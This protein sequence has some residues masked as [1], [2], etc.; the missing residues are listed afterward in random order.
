VAEA[1]PSASAGRTERKIADEGQFEL[2]ALLRSKHKR[3]GQTYEGALRAFADEANPECLVHAAHSMRE[4]FDALPVA[5][6]IERKRTA[7]LTDQVRKISTIWSRAIKTS[8]SLTAEGWKGE[9]D[10][11]LQRLLGEIAG[12][13]KWFDDEHPRH[14]LV[15]DMALDRLDPGRGQLPEQLR[16]ERARTLD[17]LTRY[18]NAVAHHEIDSSRAEFAERLAQSESFLRTFFKP[19]PIADSKEIDQILGGAS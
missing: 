16:K 1:A 3:L 17:E 7:D 5:A 14:G 4:L 19:S 10:A 13:F 18:M 8:K 15:R 12:F 9:V 2:L 11:V 6:E